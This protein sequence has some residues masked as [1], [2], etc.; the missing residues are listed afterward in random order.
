MPFVVV[1]LSLTGVF[2]VLHSILAVVAYDLI[3]MGFYPVPN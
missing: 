3:S 1:S 2:S